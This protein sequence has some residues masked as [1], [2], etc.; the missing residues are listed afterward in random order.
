MKATFRGEKEE[1]PILP[2]KN[3]RE[4][5]LPGKESTVVDVDPE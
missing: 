5:T 3:R 4:T 1:H 2:C